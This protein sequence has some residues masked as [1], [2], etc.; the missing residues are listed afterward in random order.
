M[1]EDRGLVSDMGSIIRHSARGTIRG[2]LEAWTRTALALCLAVFALVALT[3]RCGAQE[4]PLGN[5]DTPQAPPKPKTP[6]ELKPVIEGS[7]NV[8]AQATSH[9]DARLRVDVNL[10]QVPMT[11]T[12]W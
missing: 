6:E 9:R 11:V 7:G 3:A 1:R 2:G 10:V 8:T 5:V 4:N 12:A